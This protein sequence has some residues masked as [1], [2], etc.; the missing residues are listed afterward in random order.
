MSYEPATHPG[1]CGLNIVVPLLWVKV[2]PVWVKI[3]EELCECKYP[4]A[5][6]VRGRI[7][8]KKN[9]EYY[10][11]EEMVNSYVMGAELGDVGCQIALA[12]ERYRQKRFG[13]AIT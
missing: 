6:G 11:V 9:T 10:S 5:F 2:P 1:T 12:W 7:H 8:G 13:E 4:P 3:V